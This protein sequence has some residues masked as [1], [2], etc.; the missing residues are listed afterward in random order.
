MA[1]D[2]TPSSTREQPRQ[3]PNNRRLKEMRMKDVDALLAKQPGKAQYRV[4][5]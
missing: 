5:V 3:H 4:G 1:S 2:D